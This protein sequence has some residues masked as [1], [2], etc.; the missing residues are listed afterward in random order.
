MTLYLYIPKLPKFPGLWYVESCRIY[1]INSHQAP[2]LGHQDALHPA[3][4]PARAEWL[5]P[6]STARRA[7]CFESNHMFRVPWAKP[8]HV[9][10]GTGGP[11]RTPQQRPSNLEQIPEPALSLLEAGLVS[12]GYFQLALPLCSRTGSMQ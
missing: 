11:C 1:I 10:T 2:L 5:H 7:L 9:T 4:I 12:I 6:S 8:Q 3:I